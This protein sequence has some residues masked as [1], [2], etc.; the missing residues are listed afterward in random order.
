MR[1]Q[2]DA[3]ITLVEFMDFQ[4]PFCARVQPTLQ[5]IRDTYGDQVRVVFKH[6]PLSFHPKAPGAATVAEA[7]HRQG[8]FWEMQ[9]LI[10]ANQGTLDDEHYR[11]WAQQSGWM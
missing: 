11:A 10:F 1:G 2:P 4:C 3:K 9:E 5:Q 7:A 8:K 6:L